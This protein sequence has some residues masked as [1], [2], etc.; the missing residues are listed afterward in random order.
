MEPIH[1]A[2]V[3]IGA[4]PVAGGP[5]GFSVDTRECSPVCLRY[6]YYTVYDHGYL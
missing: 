3:M 4:K 6:V 2:G 1:S 5:S